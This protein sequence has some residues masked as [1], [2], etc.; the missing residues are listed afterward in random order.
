MS[1]HLKRVEPLGTEPC[2]A[3]RSGWERPGPGRHRLPCILPSGHEGEHRD[4][5]G[6]TW[7]APVEPQKDG[8]QPG[9]RAPAR[10]P[11][12]MCVRCNHLT[13]TPVIVA[14][15]D[16]GTG[17]GFTVY[18]CLGCATYYVARPERHRVQPDSAGGAA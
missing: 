1:A 16:Q 6:Q 3:R 17:P 7:A 2:G 12:R 10:K 11:I 18:A 13:D 8:T 9:Y 14:E 15:I 5:F 4:T